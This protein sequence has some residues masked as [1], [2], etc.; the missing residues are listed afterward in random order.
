MSL[1]KPLIGLEDFHWPYELFLCVMEQ[2]IE[3]AKADQ[4]PL[5]LSV[6][7]NRNSN[8]RLALRCATEEI[9]NTYQL[10]KDRLDAIRIPLQVNRQTRA[11]VDSVFR[12]VP[13]GGFSEA[14]HGLLRVLPDLDYFTPF[15][16][17]PGIVLPVFNMYLLER[18]FH[19]NVY[20]PNAEGHRVLQ[21][22]KHLLLPLGAFLTT[23]NQESAITAYMS[24][25]L[26]L[27]NIQSI[28]VP[29]GR[30]NMDLVTSMSTI[31][32]GLQGIDEDVFPDLA[33]WLS[34]APNVATLS[35]PFRQKGIKFRG[36]L[37]VL[38]VDVLEFRFT[39]DGSIW[40]EY[41]NANC[42]CCRRGV[43]KY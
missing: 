17:T 7:Y 30:V 14:S 38:D 25:L 31:H 27:P 4:S 28:S 16:F 40:V 33:I 37:E 39:K 42:N 5:L 10:A 34:W 18:F 3:K 1:S 6:H 24:I 43:L 29:L 23:Q 8:A 11:L 32:A 36:F 26:G 2:F 13:M 22:I 35:R 9:V 20:L 12:L 21:N 19:D 15:D 41:L